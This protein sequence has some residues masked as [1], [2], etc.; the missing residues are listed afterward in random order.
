MCLELKLLELSKGRYGLQ[1]LMK[2][3]AQDYGAETPFED[4]KFLDIIYATAQNNLEIKDVS[5]LKSFFDKHVKGGERIPY[6][7]YTSPLG[8]EYLESAKIS[9]ISPLGG[10][11]NGALKNDTLSRFYISKPEK[12]D[13]F[14]T[15][16]IG[17]LLDDVILEW[18]GKPFNIKTVSAIL[19]TYLD[20]AKENDPIDV[21]I[22]R[23]NK[24][25]KYEEKLLSTKIRK[26]EVEKKHVFRLIEKPT[27]EQLRLRNIWLKAEAE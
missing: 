7:E 15:K 1:D 26:I 21:K 24:D 9:E 23:K 16:D 2:A 27:E 3:L 18:N 19:L 22:L 8:I 14:G 4:A 6:N 25:G 17:F 20:S 13:E 11:E 10:I 12:L 5:A